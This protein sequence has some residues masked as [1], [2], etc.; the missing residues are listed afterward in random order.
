METGKRTE[1]I[2]N[3]MQ[4]LT[5]KFVDAL[6]LIFSGLVLSGLGYDAN[7]GLEGQTQAFYKAQWPLFMLLPAL[8][9]VLYLIPFLCIRYSKAQRAQV[10]RNLRKDTRSHLQM[11]KPNPSNKH[12]NTA[13]YVYNSCKIE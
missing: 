12:N 8:G 2:S 4:N 3:S 10:E 1:G 9:S 6:K 5:S 11:M 13:F 7:L